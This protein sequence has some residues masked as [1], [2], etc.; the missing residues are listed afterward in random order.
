MSE[1]IVIF[2]SREKQPGFGNITSIVGKGFAES[3][4][5]SYLQCIWWCGLPHILQDISESESD[6]QKSKSKS[7]SVIQQ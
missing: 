5:K 2:V 1:F 3:E 7:K 6:A 4:E